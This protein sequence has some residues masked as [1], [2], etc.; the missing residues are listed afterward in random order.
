MEKIKIRFDPTDNTL[1]VWFADPQTMAYLSPLQEEANG[2]LHLI[3]NEAGEVIGFECQFYQIKPGQLTVE[4][5]TAPLLAT[6][7]E[8]A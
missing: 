1:Q 7:L 5:E 6:L 3:K 8:H 2:D 4:L